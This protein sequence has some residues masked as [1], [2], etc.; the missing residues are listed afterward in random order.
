MENKT[1]R[2]SIDGKEVETIANRS[3]LEAAL[4]AGFYVPHLCHHPDLRPAGKCG[5]CVV[6]VEGM[7]EPCVSCTTPAED[8]MVVKTRTKRIDLLRR[9][10]METL[11]VDHPSECLECSQYLHCELQSVKQYLGMTEVL[12]VPRR[13]RPIPVDSS[14]PLFVHDFTRCIRCERCVRACN[15]LRGAGVLQVKEEGGES[16][17]SVPGEKSLAAAG[18]L[19][20]GACVE[21]CPTGAMRD[22]EEL[23]KGKKRAAALVPCRHTCPA[24]IDVPRYIRFIREKKYPEAAAVIREKVPFPRVLGHVCHHPCETVCRRAEVNEPVSIRDLKRFAAEKED[25]RLREK[26]AGREPATGKRVGVVGAGPAGLTAAYYLSRRG[27]EVTVFESLPYA[28]GM[29]RFGIPEYRLPRDVLDSEIREIEKAG[30]EIRTNTRIESLDTLMQEKGYQA[31]IVAVGAQRGHRLRIPGGDLERV[32]VGLDFL[33]EVNLGNNVEVGEKVLVAGGGNVAVD[34]AR[35]AIRIG[36]RSVHIVC[37]ETRDAMPA[38]EEEIRE[39]EKEG[40]LVHPSRTCSR[41]LGEIGGVRGVE[42]LKVESFSLD[43]DGR[44]QVE[45]VEGS[46][47]VL[48][49][50]TVI[51]A[52]GQTPDIPSGFALDLDE[53]SRVKIDPYTLESNREGIFAVGDAVGGTSWVIEAIASARRTAAAVDEYLGGSGDIE[54]HLAPQEEPGSWL[55]QCE[56]F[57]G[58]ARREWAV[59]FENEFAEAESTRCLQ[60]DL[61]L[62]ITPVKFWGEY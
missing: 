60:C 48:P 13:I 1:I 14:N 39:A 46:E 18:C 34:C 20:C 19:F 25:D 50:D 24:E 51:F 32:L 10:A 2:L 55:G 35:A 15:E 36:A 57:A 45:T 31:L 54:E 7:E 12:S 29:M 37:L 33:R 22:K 17:I 8:S 44:A 23:V 42:C 26:S 56:G 61:R 30:V 9:K 11:L 41:I 4:G 49:A 52:V 53:R 47:F 62:R 59:S 3:V 58:F 40:I 16:R 28:G 27:H 43:E 5:L 6:E 38:V 21:V